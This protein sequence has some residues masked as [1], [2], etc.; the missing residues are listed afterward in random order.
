MSNH[1]LR[2]LLVAAFMATPAMVTAQGL[3]NGDISPDDR[4]IAQV[5]ARLA[6]NSEDEW[7]AGLGLRT[8]RLFG[9]NQS[10]SLDA[11]AMRGGTR[12]SFNYLNDAIAGGTPRFGLRLFR[13]DRRR[14]D[15]YSFDSTVA[16]I[17]PR[18]TWSLGPTSSV[19]A[20]AM[21]TLS[22]IGDPGAAPSA[23][24]AADVGPQRSTVV[25]TELNLRYPGAGG[26]LRD[27]RFAL[28]LAY[29]TTSRDHDYLR[30]AARI[31]LLHALSDGNVVLRSQL[32]VGAIQ[33][34]SGTS[35]IGDRYMLGDGSIRGFAFGGFGPRDLAAGDAAL[36]GNRFA[37]L[38]F[39]AQFPNLIR[40]AEARF[41]P[42]VFVDGGSLWGLDDAAGGPAGLHTVEDSARFR[43]AAGLTLR[44]RSGIGP[45]EIYVA[46]PL[47]RENY[48]RTQNVGLSFS[49]RF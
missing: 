16:G 24:I 30:Y 7:V 28:D 35:S 3:E 43:A 49:R 4:P 12:L 13:T 32:R 18:L 22:D 41:V 38:R 8:D 20:Y 46:H 33:T 15:V 27:T 2:M 21:Y 37:V 31:S 34:L 36:G 23:L 5:T 47:A 6:Y 10:L 44:I 42:G 39:D 11:E 26:L 14:G 40:A 48:D 17:V 25:G 9:A 29:G 45:V 1:L 19:A